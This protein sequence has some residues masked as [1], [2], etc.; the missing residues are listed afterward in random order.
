MMKHKFIVAGNFQQA[1]RYAQDNHEEGIRYH[2]IAT[3]A[4]VRGLKFPASDVIYT[5]T[6]WE[7]KNFA[8]ITRVLNV[9]HSTYEAAKKT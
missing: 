8:E 2:Y 3:P 4:T 7:H 6:Y 5:G 1:N 9:V